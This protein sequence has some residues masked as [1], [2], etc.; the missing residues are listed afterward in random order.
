MDPMEPPKHKLKKAPGGPPS[1]PVPILHSP[2]RKLTVEDR[3]A[4]KIP[5]CISNWK[6]A[7]GYTIPL[8]KRLA[9]DGRGLQEVTI[10]NKFA[11][12]SEALYV[13]ERKAAEDLRV[14]NQIR[15]KMAVKEKEDREQELRDMALRARMERAGALAGSAG[16]D[17]A[18]AG[19]DERGGSGSGS[20]RAA[21]AM[22]DHG[23][24]ESIDSPRSDY[25]DDRDRSRGRGGGGG[26]GRGRSPS[27]SPSRSR[28]RSR[29]SDGDRAR[30]RSDGRSH[31]RS[32]GDSD[33]DEERGK[34]GETDE[35]RVARLQREKLRV[36]RRKE[37]ERELRLENMKVLYS[38]LDRQTQILSVYSMRHFHSRNLSYHN[39]TRVH[40]L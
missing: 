36:E 21:A 25:S 27:R 29:S 10:N 2:P 28:S 37:R 33:S 38:H 32:G 35:E 12:I 6:N 31:R 16:G 7:R 39:L 24:R 9:A 13:A 22:S 34:Y 17:E 11:M 3:Q 8:D 19:D 40:C 1:P 30:S 5:P 23:R 14:R 18:A 26:G 4:W 15:K 20:G